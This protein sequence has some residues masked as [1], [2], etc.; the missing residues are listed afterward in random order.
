MSY[1][2]QRL[3]VETQS[4]EIL[5]EFLTLALSM[6]GKRSALNLPT[7]PEQIAVLAAP[8]RWESF[9]PG[10]LYHWERDNF[11]VIAIDTEGGQD[12]DGKKLTE[13]CVGNQAASATDAMYAV[14]KK[15][16]DERGEGWKAAFRKKNFNPDD[17]TPEVRM[18][19]GL[20]SGG[21]FHT[22]VFLLSLVWIDLPK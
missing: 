21:T 3:R 4:F 19:F 7:G 5:K 11:P 13:M 6:R 9:L 2:L 1:V 10:C 16:F 12:F 22:S 15:L 14:V 20:D 18:G 8:A 17:G